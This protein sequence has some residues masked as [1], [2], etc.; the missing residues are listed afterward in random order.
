MLRRGFVL[1]VFAFHAVGAVFEHSGGLALSFGGDD[2]V[3]LDVT[4]AIK[5]QTEH[6][7]IDMVIEGWF[8]STGGHGHAQ[9]LFVLQD[10]LHI[11]EFA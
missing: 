5:N 2:W 3:T 1:S 10:S 7:V 9:T 4:P 11:V 6:T 8:R